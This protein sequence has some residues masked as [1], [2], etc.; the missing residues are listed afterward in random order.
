MDENHIWTNYQHHPCANI[1]QRWPTPWW[2]NSASAMERSLLQFL[3]LAISMITGRM[4]DTME[5]FYSWIVAFSCFNLV[6]LLGTPENAGVMQ[7]FRPFLGL[8]IRGQ[9]GRCT[10]AGT[11]RGSLSP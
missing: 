1:C 7:R 4:W 10:A 9:G 2:V 3:G 6:P 11:Y 8:P 5:T